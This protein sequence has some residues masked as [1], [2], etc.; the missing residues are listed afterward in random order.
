MKIV[1]ITQCSFCPWLCGDLEYSCNNP[2]TLDKEITDITGMPEWC[3]LD[4]LL[5]IED[6]EDD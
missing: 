1:E 4:E 3:A 5:D 2:E 6:G